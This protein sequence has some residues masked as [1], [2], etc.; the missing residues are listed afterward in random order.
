MHNTMKSISITIEHSLNQS[1][2]N[3]TILLKHIAAIELYQDDYSSLYQD[4]IFHTSSGKIKY[5][6]YC[7][8]IKD[9]NPPSQD[10]VNQ[11]LEH[12]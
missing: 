10:F 12:I 3:I 4:I 11:I 9:N 7:Q 6:S 2:H 5:S 8:Q 1:Y